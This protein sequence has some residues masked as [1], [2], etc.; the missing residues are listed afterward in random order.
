[1]GRVDGKVAIVTGAGSGIGRASA[2]LLAKE[3]AK[4]VVT[5]V[6]TEKWN[7]VVEELEAFQGIAIGMTHHVAEEEQWKTVLAKAFDTFGTI[8]VLVNCAG[9]S[10]KS[11]TTL[12]WERVLNVNLTGSYLGMKHAIP[13]MKQAGSG[14]IV[15]IASLAGLVGG[16]FNGYAASKGGIR[17]ISRAAAVDYAKDKIRVN[18]IYPGMIIT[19][20]TEGIIHHKQLKKHF[21]DI[22]PLPRFGTADDIAYGVLYLASDE[23]SFVTGTEL[24][25]DGG[26]TAS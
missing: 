19:P 16:G 18:S 22:T 23:A 20:M 4:V 1:M 11:D 25:I 8:D 10:S 2:I 14:S 13:Y 9:I 3:G 24:V 15:N 5:D 12:E 7:E 17:A 21:E 6:Q 26:T